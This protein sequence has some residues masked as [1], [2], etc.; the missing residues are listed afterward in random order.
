MTIWLWVGFIAG[1]VGLLALDLG[2][3]NRKAHV[4]STGEA[5]KWTA[6]WV[7]LAL[8]F[9]IAVFYL[10]EYHSLGIGS[11]AREH[12]DGRSAAL[13]YLLGYII[14]ESLSLDNMFVIALG[15]GNPCGAF[16]TL[17]DSMRLGS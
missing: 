5:L 11:G 15:K 2:V 3:L 8:L 6:F 4:I 13:R 9:S 1:V 14:E 17:K 16:V 7:V 10:Y 12:L